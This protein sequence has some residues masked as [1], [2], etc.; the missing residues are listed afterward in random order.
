MKTVYLPRWTPESVAETMVALANTNGG[1]LQLPTYPDWA[2]QVQFIA[3]QCQPPVIVHLQT[4][5]EAAVISIQRSPVLHALADGRVLGRDR[6]GNRELDSIAIRRLM[7][8]KSLGDFETEPVPGTRLDDLQADLIQEVLAEVEIMDNPEEVLHQIGAIT[9]NG[10]PTTLGILLFNQMPH[11][12]LP[13]ARIEFFHMVGTQHQAHQETFSG[14]LIP[15]LAAAKIYAHQIAGAY[16]LT[17]V[18]EVLTNAVLHRDYRINVPITVGIF[19]DC[20]KITS[21]GGLPGFVTLETLHRD[22]FYRNP[23]LAKVLNQTGVTANGG[24]F[25]LTCDIQSQAHRAPECDA[26]NHHFSLVLYKKTDNS[27]SEPLTLNWRQKRA[28]EYIREHGSITYRAFRALCPHISRQ[29]LIAD[30][31]ELVEQNL[32]SEFGKVYMQNKADQE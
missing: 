5:G 22:Q 14:P 3:A 12:W 2:G 28:L 20:L 11:R 19:H 23:R 15:T 18:S 30:L 17:M 13:Q 4:T 32:L 25:Y 10:Q 27:M 16:P 9:A 21:P 29:L 26:H 8:H 1:I 31:A 6:Q 24:L 7:Q